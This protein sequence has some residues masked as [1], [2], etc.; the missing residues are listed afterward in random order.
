[1]S[2]RLELKSEV[3]RALAGGDSAAAAADFWKIHELE[4]KDRLASGD[5]DQSESFLER[6][7]GYDMT[8]CRLQRRIPN[9]D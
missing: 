8:D 3:L 9:G 7:Q 6:R 5:S 1:M 2:P 4:P